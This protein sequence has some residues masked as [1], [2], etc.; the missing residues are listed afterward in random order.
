MSVCSERIDERTE[1]SGSAKL[2]NLPRDDVIGRPW[3]D[4]VRDWTAIAG[5]AL[6]SALETPEQALVDLVLL[7]EPKPTRSRYLLA[8]C[9]Q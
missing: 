3:L 6:Q 7:I 5:E 1:S 4:F 9:K 8:L 2:R